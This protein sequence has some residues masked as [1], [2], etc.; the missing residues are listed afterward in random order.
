MGIFL[1]SEEYDKSD[2]RDYESSKVRPDVDSLVVALEQRPKRRP[3][4]VIVDTIAM[5]DVLVVAMVLWR[6]LHQSDVRPG[7]CRAIF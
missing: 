7:F 5:L 1:K 4:S 3:P 2:E 6:I